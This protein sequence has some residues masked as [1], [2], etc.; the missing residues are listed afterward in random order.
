ME[1]QPTLADG[2]TQNGI[3]S[4]P[5]SQVKPEFRALVLSIYMQ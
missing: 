4:R 5:R 1:N 2:Q 3:D